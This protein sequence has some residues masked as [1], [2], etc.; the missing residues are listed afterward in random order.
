MQ[1]QKTLRIENPCP[2]R[3]SRMTPS[4][5]G[6]FCNSCSKTVV[7]FRNKSMEE[8]LANIEVGGCGIFTSEQLPNQKPMTWRKW[9]G[10][11]ALAFLSFLGM[12]PA[13]IQAQTQVKQETIAHMDAD[14]KTIG[15]AYDVAVGKSNTQNTKRRKRLFRR[16]RPRIL[17]GCPDF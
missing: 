3:L 6:F 12:N 15:K 7:D 9:L 10:F 13:P 1:E 11:Y 2:V 16:K 4:E 17:M 5:S 14:G 8:V